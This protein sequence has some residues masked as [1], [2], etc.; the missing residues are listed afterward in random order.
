MT[1]TM[2]TDAGG[3]QRTA[4]TPDQN[5]I[6]DHAAGLT[7]SITTSA[8]LFTPPTGCTFAEISAPAD[9]WVRTDDVAVV[10]PVDGATSAP[11]YV[12]AGVPKMVP[13]TPGVPLRA[14]S[15][16]GSAVLV[17]VLP[18]KVRS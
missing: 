14:I 6:Y 17:T 8:V 12:P 3:I 2:Q 15:A 16:G 5:P 4:L 13:V 1:Q 11:V 18:L 7:K 10:V 9:V